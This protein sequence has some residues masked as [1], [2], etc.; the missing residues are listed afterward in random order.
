MLEYF[1]DQEKLLRF[2]CRN[3]KCFFATTDAQKLFNHEQG[4]SA[5]TQIS[6]KQVALHRPCQKIRKELEL[7]GIIPDPNW[8]NW[9]FVAFD[10]ESLMTE[11]V[12]FGVPRDVHRLVSIGVKA[13]FG[14]ESEFYLEREDMD[15]LSVKQL[16][17]DFVS[18]LVRLRAKM[19]EFIPPT[20]IEGHKKYRQL[21]LQKDFK[22]LPV[23]KQ[24]KIK[25]KR[26]YL[27]NSMKL[28]VVSWNGEKY[29]HNVIWAPLLDIL[30]ENERDFEKK[31]IIRRGT[32]I[33]EFT[34]SS[35]VF[36][37]FLNYSNPMSL[38]SFSRSCGVTAASKTTFPYEYFRDIS[39]LHRMETFPAYQH[40]KPGSEYIY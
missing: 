19:L 17:R 5:V 25:H 37:D 18:L 6:C 7:E 14:T 20:V 23:E 40:F 12:Q 16:M 9:N 21:E 13:S 1:S 2:E 26:R 33:M 24:N 32:G 31:S 8:H 3:H 11:T 27:E 4:C 38:D 29:D 34:Y 22:K 35:L 39:E 36:R 30:Q 15:P 28:I 10:C